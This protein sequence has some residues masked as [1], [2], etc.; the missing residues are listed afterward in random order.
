VVSNFLRQAIEGRPLTIYGAGTHTRSF[1]FVDDLLEGIIR[2]MNTDPKPHNP[3]FSEENLIHPVNLGNPDEITILRLADIV[4]E[5]TGSDVPIKRLPPTSD[6]PDRRRPDI[7]YAKKLLDWE[8][9]VSLKEGLRDTLTYFRSLNFSQYTDFVT[10]FKE[11]KDQERN[12][13]H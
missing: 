12:R 6:D 5:L 1:Q 4:L 11:K 13:L 8:P 9:K 10:Q 3:L 7:S 2:L